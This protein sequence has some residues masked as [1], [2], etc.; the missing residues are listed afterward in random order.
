[1]VKI[2]KLMNVKHKPNVIIGVLAYDKKTAASHDAAVFWDD[3]FPKG[4][5]KSGIWGFLIIWS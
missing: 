2:I 3:D 1:M 5:G 4:V